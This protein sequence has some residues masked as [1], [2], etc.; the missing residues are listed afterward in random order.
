M[1]WDALLTSARD[2]VGIFIDDKSNIYLCLFFIISKK[3]NVKPENV[4]ADFTNSLIEIRKSIFALR[5]GKKQ[6]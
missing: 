6:K 4:F 2:W 3:E 5:E 1:V